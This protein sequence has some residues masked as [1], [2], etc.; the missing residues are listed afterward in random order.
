MDLP[1][2]NCVAYLLELAREQELH[3]SGRD[4]LGQETQRRSK[5]LAPNNR[6]SEPALIKIQNL[7][8]DCLEIKS[9]DGGDIEDVIRQHIVNSEKKAKI[10]V[11]EFKMKKV[12]VKMMEYPKKVAT[13]ENNF[14]TMKDSLEVE[15]SNLQVIKDKLY[16]QNKYLLNENE[17]LR[18]EKLSLNKEAKAKETEL[19]A[20]KTSL[21]WKTAQV[22][23]LKK[24]ESYTANVLLLKDKRIEALE[25]ENKELKTNLERNSKI[26]KDSGNLMVKGH[27][28]AAEMASKKVKQNGTIMMT[29][30]DL[31]L[32][33][34]GKGEEEL[35]SFLTPP[36]VIGEQANIL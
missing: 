36:K 1:G 5:S 33:E 22:E 20:L 14:S 2:K 4:L 31:L 17:I 27:D 3:K 9:G 26:L 7:G 34:N 11:H 18:N 8:K 32:L 6:C 21:N 16:T 12:E 24:K 23:V 35:Q 19:R 15:V 13:Q 10:Q 25:N 29:Q 28:F 30:A